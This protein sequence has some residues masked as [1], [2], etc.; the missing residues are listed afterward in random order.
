[1]PLVFHLKDFL[2]GL[3]SALLDHQQHYKKTGKL[4]DITLRKILQADDNIDD[5]EAGDAQGRLKGTP[6]EGC[7]SITID[8]LLQSTP[9]FQSLR[10]HLYPDAP[11]T[12]QDHLETFCLLALTGALLHCHHRGHKNIPKMFAYIRRNYMEGKCAFSL[13]GSSGFSTLIMR[14]ARVHFEVDNKA[15]SRFFNEALVGIWAW[16]AY[17]QVDNDDYNQQ[18]HCDDTGLYLYDHTMMVKSLEQTLA[19]LNW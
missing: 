5:A 13:R 10:H 3:Y 12:L 18:L 4:N 2:R 1:M 15:L 19:C 8:S 11:L 17:N 14:E 16:Y 9:T 6:F 7:P